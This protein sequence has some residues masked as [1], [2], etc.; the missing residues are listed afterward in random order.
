MDNVNETA[1][2]PCE[3]LDQSH[4]SHLYEAFVEAFSD[5]VVPFAL[6]ETQ[7]RNHI[8]LNA[9]DLD[10]TVG[11]FDGD[12]LVG[13]SLNGFG[14]WNGVPTAYDAGTGVLPGYRR[15]GLSERMFEKMLS[16]F[17][18]EGIRQF[19]LEV[20]TSNEAAIN[21]YEKLGFETVRELALLQCDGRIMS[22]GRPP[23]PGLEIRR[24][25][26][27]DWDL[28]TSFW[29]A[30]PS[31]QNSVD[32]VKRSR[33]V[34]SI[35]GAFSDDRCVGY[36][37]FSSTFG[38]VAQ[39]A[40]DKAHRGVGIGAALVQA[41]QSGTAEGFSMQVINIDKS[42]AEAMAFFQRLGFYERLSQF[43]MVMPVSVNEPGR[44]V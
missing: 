24:I 2:Q 30:R 20:V 18:A 28:L 9:V 3:F 36:I 44:E 39:L 31:W 29:E 8:I 19:L 10:R 25:G 7:F 35:I 23:T 43:E 42:N 16:R 12:K 6:T 11:C 38:R 13:F 27:P 4:F 32:A 26:E 33:R 14:D 15:R 34:K 17:A 1:L 40:V 37:I 41:M 5:Y 22:E 21:L